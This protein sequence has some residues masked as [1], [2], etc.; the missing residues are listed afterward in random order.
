M[1]KL[2]SKTE[3]AHLKRYAP[4]Q[5]PEELAQRFRVDVETVRAKIEEL[6]LNR[7]AG[8]AALADAA[9]A[10]FEN[11]VRLLHAKDYKAAAEIFEKI[12]AETDSR[13]LADRA[14]QF[15]NMCNQRLVSPA[16][17]E[18]TFLAAVIDKNRG[19]LKAARQLCQKLLDSPSED[20][21]H[22]FL[23]ASI[24]ALSGEVDKALTLLAKAIKLDPK[25]RV[26]AYH[27]SDFSSLRGREEFSRLLSGGG[28]A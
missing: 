14:R 11:G 3:V 26:H 21:K 22:F 12:I 8:A 17:T 2:W 1:E 4:S 15:L 9:L 6:G 19:D 10:A 27:D 13:Q 23:M 24:E 7:N 28:L 18:D 16:S 5:S 25:N 20:S